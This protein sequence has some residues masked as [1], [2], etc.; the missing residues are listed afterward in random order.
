MRS[1]LKLGPA[2]LALISLYFAPFWGRDA[3]RALVSPYGGLEDRT[4]T[5]AANTFGQLFD[6]GL[7]GLMRVSNA[8]AALKLVIAAAFVAYLIEFA[9]SLVVE[10]EPNHETIDAVL[11][12]AVTAIGIW[13]MPALALD[14]TAL[15]RLA[16]TQLLL[17]SGALIVIMVER[18]VEE[19]SAVAMPQ[20][21]AAEARQPVI[22]KSAATKQSNLV[23]P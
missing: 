4:Q 10:R 1:H 20:L 13:A 23:L 19:A 9:R 5:A 18:H 3:V 6:L 17:V 15:V 16:A 11:A 2:N 21:T 12:L 22:A 14:D 8:L 7:E